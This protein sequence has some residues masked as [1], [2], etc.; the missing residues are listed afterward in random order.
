MFLCFLGRWV[1]LF[2]QPFC[3]MTSYRFKFPLKITPASFSLDSYRGSWAN[4]VFQ[5]LKGNEPIF[6]M[7]SLGADCSGTGRGLQATKKGHFYVRTKLLRPAH[8]HLQRPPYFPL[9][10]SSPTYKGG[11]RRRRR[12]CSCYDC[13]DTEVQWGQSFD[14]DLAITSF[15][16]LAHLWVQFCTSREGIGCPIWCRACTFITSASLPPRP[17]SQSML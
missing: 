13:I 11:R 15:S 8:L 16:P 2:I 9:E 12:E 7:A 10:Y 6:G 14:L 3:L 4:I 17:P 5:I 1:N